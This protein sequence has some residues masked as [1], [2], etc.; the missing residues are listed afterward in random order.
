[1]S[2]SYTFKPNLDGLNEEIAKVIDNE[3]NPPFTKDEQKM[4]MYEIVCKYMNRN[5]QLKVK[6][7]IVDL[8]EENKTKKIYGKEDR[9]L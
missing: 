6:S 5:V 2:K 4:R 3:G 1:M 9:F 7:F 8:E